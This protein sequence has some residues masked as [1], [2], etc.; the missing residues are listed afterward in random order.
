MLHPIQ[1]ACETLSGYSFD[2]V[3]G[4]HLSEADFIDPAISREELAG[5]SM[6]ALRRNL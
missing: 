6:G 3:D 4:M 2:E 1:P 5:C